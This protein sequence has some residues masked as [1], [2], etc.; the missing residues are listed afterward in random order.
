MHIYFMLFSPLFCLHGALHTEIWLFQEMQWKYLT[1]LTCIHNLKTSPLVR[2]T[3]DFCPEKQRAGRSIA[4]PFLTKKDRLTSNPQFFWTHQRAEVTEQLTGPK[5]KVG[6]CL[7]GEETCQPGL[8]RPDATR[9]WARA[10]DKL[11]KVCGLAKLTV[12]VPGAAQCREVYIPSP[13]LFL[14]TTQDLIISWKCPLCANLGQKKS[15][16]AKGQ[17]DSLESLS[18][19]R[20]RSSNWLG[21]GTVCLSDRGS[22]WEQTL[23][24]GKRQGHTE[25]TFS[26]ERDRRIKKVTLLRPKDSVWIQDWDFIRTTDTDWSHQFITW[27]SQQMP[28]R[29][30]KRQHTFLVNSLSKLGIGES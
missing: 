17:E 1:K 25:P 20:N 8:S 16:K 30:W 21:K 6:W 19:T 27:S 13:G 18:S 11:V 9:H 29:S 26:A 28:K 15:R 23:P 7:Q 10:G 3:C 12:W 2:K 24:P 14:H 22:K 5:P 4:L